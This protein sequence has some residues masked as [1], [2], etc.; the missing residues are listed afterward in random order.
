MPALEWF[1]RYKKYLK[2]QQVVFL[3]CDS[4]YSKYLIIGKSGYRQIQISAAISRISEPRQARA[5]VFKLNILCD[6]HLS[7]YRRVQLI[8]SEYSQTPTPPIIGYHLQR[9]LINLFYRQ[10]KIFDKDESSEVLRSVVPDNMK[11][12]DTKYEW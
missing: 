9:E 5:S 11:S 3:L 4:N 2:I 10:S 8:I 6:I 1:L 12:W 7:Y